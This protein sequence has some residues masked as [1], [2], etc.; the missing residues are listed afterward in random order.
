MSRSSHTSCRILALPRFAVLVWVLVSFATGALGAES[1]APAATTGKTDETNTQET[2]RSYLQ[3]QEQLHATQL[4][5]ERNRKE[6]DAVATESAKVF[7]AR[8]QGIEQA[9]A[10]QRNQE[11]AVM[12]SSNKVV[13]IVAGLFAGLGFVAML[14]MAYLQWRTINRLAEI[15]AALPVAHAFGP[16]PALAALGAGDARVFTAGPAEQANQRL[17]GALEQLEQ[18]IHQLEHSAPPPPN[19]GALP[20]PTA[21]AASSLP[22]GETASA[23]EAAR[24]TMLL[25]KGQSLLNLD[26]AEEAL[27]CFDQALVLDANHAEAL[28]KKG[29]ALERLRK[30][31]E[32]IACY[33][34]AIA[35]DNSLTMAYLYKGGLFNRMERFGEAL[36]CYEQAL[37]TQ[38]TR[39]G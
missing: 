8:L 4:A 7:A 15:A 10:S 25:G 9:L 18:R 30:L 20:E 5:I 26:Q 27:A 13:L 29:A 39:R 24:L 3:L 23:S 32:A 38:E 28:V 35:A 37:R 31:D 17:L 33:D 34:R 6:A 11:L 1:T 14:F 2:L 21:T 16:G 36:E 12:Q 22:N 19:N